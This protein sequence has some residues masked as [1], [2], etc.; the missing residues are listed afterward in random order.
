MIEKIKICNIP[1]GAAPAD[2]I[3][4]GL[5]GMLQNV[6][7][8]KSGIVDAGQIGTARCTAEAPGPGCAAELCHLAE[9]PVFF[10]P[11]LAGYLDTMLDPFG[12]PF[13]SAFEKVS[14]PSAGRH[15]TYPASPPAALDPFRVGKD[16]KL[17]FIG[18]SE[19]Y[20]SSHRHNSP[21]SDFRRLRYRSCIFNQTR[22][23]TRGP[24]TQVRN[25]D[26]S[27]QPIM[28]RGD[29]RALDAP[30]M[31]STRPYRGF[32]F[33][34]PASSAGSHKEFP[35]NTK[36]FPPL[37]VEVQTDRPDPCATQPI[38]LYRRPSRQLSCR[39]ESGGPRS[40]AGTDS[41]FRSHEG[42]YHADADFPRGQATGCPVCNRGQSDHA[43]GTLCIAA[44][45]NTR[46]SPS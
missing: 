35:E 2:L 1:E 23:N 12:N 21:G 29:E 28:I 46:K 14:P 27:G 16:K 17:A 6:V 11:E 39:N 4:Q 44:L 37:P 32:R 24:I 10:P 36:L 9:I 43:G 33:R 19:H 22:N 15:L 38:L 45:E 31:Q 5:M 13:A 25:A 8:P 41:L 7:L 42:R 26:L 40:R 3:F 20:Q 30:A 18:R 34:L